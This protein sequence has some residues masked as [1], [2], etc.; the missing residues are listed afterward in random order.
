MQNIAEIIKGLQ[1][2]RCGHVDSYALRQLEFV[3]TVAGNTVLVP[4]T[5]GQCDICGEQ[6]MDDMTSAKLFETRQKLATGKV[7]DF[8]PVGQTFRSK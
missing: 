1:C 5:V 8:V 2:F 4:I 6:I 3:V 7:D